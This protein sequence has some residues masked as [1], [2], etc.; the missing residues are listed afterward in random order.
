[1][2]AYTVAAAAVTLEVPQKWLDNILSHHSVTGVV[3]SRQGVSRRLSPQAVLTLEIAIRLSEAF[4]IP[5][6]RALE[7][8]QASLQ[9][10]SVSTAGKRIT[11]T[12]DIESIESDLGARLANAVEI[13]PAPRRGRP[14]ANTSAT[15]SSSGET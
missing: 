2:R 15:P 8:A 6:G 3:K 13:A 4:S 10:P 12:I 11:L 5:F 1:M 7:L 9:R 14:P